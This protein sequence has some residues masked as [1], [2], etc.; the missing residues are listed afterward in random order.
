MNKTTQMLN[1]NIKKGGMVY[2]SSASLVL[3]PCCD[4]RK[5]KIRRKNPAKAEI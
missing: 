1:V 5:E 3:V 4:K 2:F